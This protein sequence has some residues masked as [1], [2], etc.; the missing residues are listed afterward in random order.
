MKRRLVVIGPV[1]PPYHGVTVS[2]ALI[3][4][5]PILA[6]SFDVEHLDTSDRRPTATIGRWDLTNIWLGLRATW[7]LAAIPRHSGGVVYLPLSQ[8]VPA[9]LRDSLYVHMARLRGWRVA[10]HLRG[11]ELRDLYEA[12]PAPLRAWMRLTLRRLDSVAVMG[13]SLRRVFEGLVPPERIAVVPNGTPDPGVNGSGRDSNTVLFLSNLWR[14]KGV[15]EAVEAA[16]LVLREQPSARFLF[17][18]DWQDA[19]FR[20]TVEERAQEA[21]DAVRF[22]PALSGDDL[23]GVL[24]EAG[25]LLFPPSGAEGH[26]RVVLEGIAAGLPIV[27]TRRG[28]IPDTVDDGESGFLLEHPD[29]AEIADRLLL[30]MRDGELR[31]RMGRAARTRYLERFT[32]EAADGAL[33]RWL[34]GVAGGA[35]ARTS[36]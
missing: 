27:T 14:R 5:S 21:G 17:V 19:S 11:S 8:N 36:D 1:P 13:P 31:D 29:P 7:R 24:S 15:V 25:I 6:G 18:G 20:R 34:E 23:R 22:L 16:C 26:P 2:T 30:L 32:Q 33:C 12:Q 3:L 35:T 28:C 4:R 10:A 9:F